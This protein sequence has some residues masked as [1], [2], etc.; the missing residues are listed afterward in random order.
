MSWVLLGLGLALVMEGLVY[1][2]APSAVEDLLAL[3]RSLSI[4]QRRL[5]GMTAVALGLVL[6]SLARLVG[7]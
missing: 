7:L 2:L 6:V 1:V 3:L 4:E 5:I